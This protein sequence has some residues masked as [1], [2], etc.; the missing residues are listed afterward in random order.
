[1]LQQYFFSVFTKWH[2]LVKLAR[3]Y[4]KYLSTPPFITFKIP[5]F[6]G[7]DKQNKFQR[8]CQFSWSIVNRTY[9]PSPTTSQKWGRTGREKAAEGKICFLLL[10][11]SLPEVVASWTWQLFLS[12]ACRT[13]CRVLQSGVC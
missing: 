2:L 8:R 11:L 9:Q 7:F 6:D 1:M 4:Q 12:V 10:W 3:R 5:C 13:F